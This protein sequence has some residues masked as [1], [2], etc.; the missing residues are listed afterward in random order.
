MKKDTSLSMTQGNPTRLLLWF[1]L[2]MLIGNL[3]KQTYNL[4]DHGPD[5]GHQRGVLH[6][7][8]LLVAAQNGSVNHFWEDPS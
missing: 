1:A 7:A 6:A 2:Q 4:V 5:M 8:L 3:F